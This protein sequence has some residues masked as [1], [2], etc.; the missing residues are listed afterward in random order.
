M[1][2]LQT[3]LFSWLETTHF[4]NVQTKNKA[5][6]LPSYAKSASGNQIIVEGNFILIGIFYLIVRKEIIKLKYCP[7]TILM[8]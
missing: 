3:A 6:V 8:S 1:M 5:F 7:I 4:E 2:L